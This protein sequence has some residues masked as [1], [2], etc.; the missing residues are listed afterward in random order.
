MSRLRCSAGAVAITLL[1]AVAAPVRAQTD[2]VPLARALVAAQAPAA[3]DP[4][5]TVLALL[6][7]ALQQPRSPLAALLVAEAGRWI[8][9][10]QDAARV[11]Q[12]LDAASARAGDERRHG[13]LAQELAVLRWRLVR[14]TA[15][16]EAAGAFPTAGH[17]TELLACGPFGDA[18]DAFTGVVFAPELRF[19][20]PGAVLPGRGGLATTAVARRRADGRRIELAAPP[21]R[22]QGCWYGRWRVRATAD[23]DG[24][25]EVEHDGDFQLFVDGVELLRSER[26]LRTAPARLFAGVRLPAG[27]HDVVVKTN[28][29]GRAAVALRLVDAEGHALA[30]VAPLAAGEEAP[31]GERATRTA[32]TFVTG[33]A[34][35]AR[36]AAA[37]DAEP[38]VRIA[39]VFGAARDGDGDLAIDLAEPLRAAPPDAPADALAWA[40]VL[41]QLALPDEQ[42]KAEA[43]ALEERAVAALPDTHHAA[44]VTRSAH[45]EEQDKR[46]DALRLLAAHPQPGPETFARRADV[47]RQLR[48]GGELPP[49][50]DAWRAACPRDSRPWAQAA[51]DLQGSRASSVLLEL[52]ERSLAL[53]P[54]QPA[55]AA[56]ACRDAIA[57]GRFD[58]ARELA[59]SAW[60][61]FGD[62]P[63][64]GRLRLLLDVATAQ[65]DA[66]PL[67]DALA[68]VEAHPDCDAATLLDLAARHEGGGDAEAAKRC[69]QRALL[70]DA[71][72]PALR[73]WLARLNGQP[74][75]IEQLERFRRDGRAAIAAFTATDREQ[76][77]SSTVLIDQQLL[78][79]EPDGSWTAE[80]H[81]LRRVNDQAGVEALGEGGGLGDADEVLLVRTIGPDG[82]ESVPARIEG[83]YSFQRLAPGSFVEWRYRDHGEAPG[84]RTL[85]IPEFLF[86]SGDE[87]CLVTELVVVL[88]T[89]RGELR[90]RGLAEPTSTAALL[91]GRTVHVH[92]RAAVDALPKARFLPPVT[93]LLPIAQVGEDQPPFAALREHRV[94]SGRRTRVTAPLRTAA[95][96]ATAGVDGAR[97]R[98]EAI[99]TFCQGIETG[100]AD[101]ALT[102]LLRQ[103]GNRFVLAVALLRAAD[104]TVL[105]MACRDVRTLPGSADGLFADGDELGVP[106]A[107]LVLPDGERLPLFVDAPRHWPL[108]RVPGARAG[109]VATVL[110]TDGPEPFFLPGVPTSGRTIDV[111]GRATITG[112][113]VVLRAAVE[114]G[115]VEGFAL[116]EQLRQLPENRRKLAARQIAQQVFQGQRVEDAVL[117]A[118]PPGGPARIEATLKCAPVQRD[119]ERFVVPLPLPAARLAASFGDRAERALPWQIDADMEWTWAI[120]LDPGPELRV[121]ALPQP[122]AVREDPLTLTLDVT[123]R[124]G[125]VACRRHVRVG[126]A[127]RPAAVFGDWLRA[128]AAADR[129][130]QATLELQPLAPK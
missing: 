18:G 121:V 113:D 36:A 100:P 55:V 66:H 1:A 101:D 44:R 15:G 70:L 90:T 38:A 92:T 105:P 63:S 85:A 123:M 54:D 95:A 22:R 126:A 91:D 115:D 104:F 57:L 30:G 9:S 26:W 13:L 122:I 43:R 110:A 32:A 80:V 120:E 62:P 75:A 64:F 59:A 68:A 109:T 117:G 116:A 12:A 82:T 130:D 10:V 20:E 35:L 17:A 33:E 29:N 3:D 119:G 40:R 58:R 45:A 60:P 87:P 102:A 4:D 77:F 94:Q 72:R 79:V 69:L 86:G 84:A 39:A 83:Q 88:P 37:A 7:A 112:R 50:F 124:D 71:E 114:L 47:L 46:E 2:V 56:A 27:A 6:D 61:T 106:G 34:L 19:P 53:R 51:Q 129:A 8:G 67:R 24:F 25:V 125:V 52:R 98:A 11:L 128:L 42:R 23:A 16:D 127:V 99:W 65:H 108:G 49:L 78:V 14:A 103:K 89:G 107:L 74:S 73:A 48:F 96:R 93:E 118:M 28:T 111:R 76:R 81:A 5:A 31:A 97:A 21:L 41:R